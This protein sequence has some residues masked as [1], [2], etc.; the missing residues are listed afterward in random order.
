MVIFQRWVT[1]SSPLD[2][3]KKRAEYH[4]FVND[5]LLK[6]AEYHQIVNGDLLLRKG[7]IQC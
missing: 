3:V 2:E 4:R 7:G 5:D 1:N 6:R